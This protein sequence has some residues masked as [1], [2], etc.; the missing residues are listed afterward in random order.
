MRTRRSVKWIA[1]GAVAAFG[2]AGFWLYFSAGRTPP[3][4]TEAPARAAQHVGSEVCAGCHGAEHT[5]WRGS[6]HDLA[7]QPANA[8]TVLGDFGDAKFTD[9]GVTSTFFTRDAKFLVHTEGPDGRLG[10]FELRY[11]FGVTPLQQYLIELPGGRLQALGIAWDAR[12]KQHGGQR[13]FHLYAGQKLAAGDPLHWTGIEQ[14]WNYQCADCHSTNLEKNYDAATRT[15]HTTWSELDVACEACHGPGS[16]HVRCAQQP[17]SARRS[18]TSNGL[19]VPLD[20]RRGVTWTMDP[21]R[22]IAKRS[23]ELASHREIETCARC[24]SRRGQFAPAAGR[25]FLDAYRPALLESGLYHVDGQM[26]GEVYNYGSFLQSRMYARGVTCSDCHEPHSGEL[27]AAGNALCAQCHAPATFDT[28]AHHRH[29]QDSAGARCAA[30]HMPTATYME[31][32]ARHDHSFRIPRPDLAAE[33]GTPDACAACHAD[34]PAGWTAREFLRWVP[35]PEGGG[36]AFAPAFHKAETGAPGVQAGLLTVLGDETLP[37][38]VRASAARRMEPYLGAAMLPALGQALR[39]RDPLVRAAAVSSLSGLDPAGR[40]R[41]LAP[42]L[43]D[44]DR[45]VRMEAARALAGEP[46]RQID[47]RYA[48]ALVRAIG[49]HLAAE[50]FNADRPEAQLNIGNLLGARGDFADALAAYREA[51]ALEPGFAPAAANLADLHR[52]Q[53][54]DV[55]AEQVLR[56][57]L[58]RNAADASLHHALGLTLV[59]RKQSAEAQSELAQAA[60]LDPG[61]PHHAYVYAVALHDGDEPEQALRVLEGALRQHPYDRAIL[62]ALITYQREAGQGDEAEANRALLESL[63]PAVP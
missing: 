26:R 7:M 46:E 32:D 33:L 25:R 40:A 17:E 3:S 57:A 16:E 1:V 35:Q 62:S 53:G 15:Y 49:E 19:S 18:G 61:N 56:D 59:R 48:P 13:W 10:D 44:P 21:A 2:V 20:E 41:A 5:A 4:E 52:A 27:R 55:R 29:A 28:P 31:I 43:T 45:N 8:Q 30:C 39:D 24:H 36:G 23:I 37:A 34:R 51:L 14:N 12:P 22:G 42:R 11:T 60:R 63:D 6:H 47:G 50:R 58:A 38:I 54:D 9:G